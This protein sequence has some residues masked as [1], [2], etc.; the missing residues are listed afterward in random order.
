[1]PLNSHASPLYR[2]VD[3]E[4]KTHYGDNIPPQYVQKGYHVVSEQGITVYTI[5]PASE[6]PPP[7]PKEE[8]KK[9]TPLTTYERGLLATYINE[10]ELLQ[11]KTRK[12]ADIDTISQLTRENIQLLENQFHHLTKQAGDHERRGRKVPEHLR[13]DISTTQEKILNMLNTIER[14]RQQ[15]IEA[16]QRFDRDLARYRELKQRPDVQNHH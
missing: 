6:I 2:W 13:Q 5:K 12:L 14:Y 15:K 3:N 16:A 7:E 9:V 8:K 11:A 4:G 1:M 10:E